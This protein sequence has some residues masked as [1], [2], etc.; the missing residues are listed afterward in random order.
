MSHGNLLDAGANASKAFPLHLPAD[1]QFG[2]IAHRF[3]VMG[4]FLC[5]RRRVQGEGLMPDE[6]RRLTFSNAELK[7]AVHDNPDRKE[8]NVPT[9]DVTDVT[10]VRP[11]DN[12]LFEITYFDFAKHKERKIRIDEDEALAAVITYCKA[13][14]IPLP[15]ASRKVIRVINQKFCLDALLGDAVAGFS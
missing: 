15:R 5:N 2:R 8:K 1:K 13:R 6:F 11:K 3:W 12:F 4:T 14:G 9:G 7:D 10:S